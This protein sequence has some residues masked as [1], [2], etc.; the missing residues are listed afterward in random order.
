MA[1]VYKLVRHKLVRK[2][3]CC[4]ERLLAYNMASC[5]AMQIYFHQNIVHRKKIICTNRSPHADYY[6]KNL[7]TLHKIQN[8]TR[9]YSKDVQDQIQTIHSN[10][11]IIT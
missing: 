11:S 9:K 1:R 8:L 4:R 6:C 5:S 2:Y 3:F 7:V 10:A